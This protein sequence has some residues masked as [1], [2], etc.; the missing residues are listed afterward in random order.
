MV[1]LKIEEQH[2]SLQYNNYKESIMSDNNERLS[3]EFSNS[4]DVDPLLSPALPSP[5]NSI[6]NIENIKDDKPPSQMT[7]VTAALSYAISS[8]GI[9][10]ALKMTLTSMAF[11]SSLFVALCQS[12]FTVIGLFALWLFGHIQFP[13]PSWSN[14]MAVQPLPLIQIFNVACGLIG[15]KLVSIPMFTVLRRVSIPMTLL[16]EVYILTMPTTTSIVASVALLMLGSLIA[17][18]ND[19]S[20]NFVG[21]ISILISAVATTAYGTS[22]KMLLSGPKK[23]TKWELLFYNSLFAIPILSVAVHYRGKGYPAVYNYDKWDSP[24]FLL[25]LTISITMGLVLNFAILWNT[26]T[27]GPLSTTVMGSAKNVLTT[28]LGILGLGGDYIFTVTN[29]LGLNVSMGGALLYSYVKFKAKNLPK[30]TLNAQELK[31]DSV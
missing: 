7:A 31:G 18:A 4:K 14:M 8:I 24:K 16:A 11:P 20:F 27:N 13:R 9:Q 6:N 19:L 2:T 1:K 29:F 10:V 28:Y 15:T 25:V 23:R 21:Y 5:N 30:K 26:Q 22:S 17:A 12:I 3:D